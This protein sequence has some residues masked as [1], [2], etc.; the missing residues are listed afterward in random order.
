[1]QLSSKPLINA[2]QIALKVDELA[3]R[4]SRDHEGRE[5]VMVVVLKGS[6]VFAADLMRKL[7]VPV[8]LEFAR[9]RS[10]RNSESTGH[11]ECTVLPDFSLA[12]KHVLVVE[13][14]LDTGR[15]AATIMESVR[16]AG[17][18]EAVLCTLFDKPSRRV[19]PISPDYS[20][21]V[22]EDRFVVG[23]G[24]DYNERWRELRD[25]FVLESEQESRLLQG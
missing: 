24:L 12:G 7:A 11:V 25:L 18:A 20:G 19:V 13:D 4:I 14:I 6:V 10:Y 5:L 22:L 9:A 16:K 15:T 1:M 8:T 3:E 21:F 17:P 23:Y 2:E